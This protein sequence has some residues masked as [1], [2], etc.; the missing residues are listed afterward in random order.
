MSGD[1]APLLEVNGL[2]KRFLARDGKGVVTAVNGVSLAVRPGETLGIV[3][4]SGCG[5]STLGRLMLRLMEPDAGE[6]RFAGQ[7]LLSLTPSALRRR[8]RDMQLIFQ[9][10]YASL[11]PRCNVGDSI[12]EPLAIH[13]VGDGGARSRRVAELLTLVGL[14][15][16]AA[17][18]Y[19]HEFSGGQRQR[20]GIARAI[21]LEPKLIVADEPVS[22]LDVS[23][24]A[25]VL[26]LLVD[27]RA[28]LGLSYV[29]ISHD[30][31]VVEH[32]S[33]RVAVMYLGRIVEVAEKRRLYD[34]P[35]HPYTSALFSAIP[36]PDA[37]RR[38]QRTILSGDVPN[39]EAPPS[40]C[41][42]HPRC[43]RVMP[44]CVAERP[45]TY[46]VGNGATPHRV[47]CFLHAPAA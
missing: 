30:L 38:R 29:F 39:P 32:V 13:R 5:K 24:Q 26:N 28:R 9:D 27:L 12:A 45:A 37:A 19:P 40:G 1:T 3:G 44:R 25:Q 42:F 7:D 34:K 22:A 6:V 4:E 21:A 47:D 43:P 16:D 11:D 41:A 18:R 20:I 31:A 15:P 2:V 17:A 8:R 23:I 35:A 46:T 36:E 33:D 10:P 14:E